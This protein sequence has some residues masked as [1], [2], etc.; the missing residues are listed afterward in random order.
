MVVVSR[1]NRKRPKYSINNSISDWQV[2]SRETTPHPVVRGD[3]RVLSHATTEVLSPETTKLLSQET[4]T[5]ERKERKENITKE[6]T[7]PRP[8]GPSGGDSNNQGNIRKGLFAEYLEAKAQ[9]RAYLS[10]VGW[11]NSL[12]APER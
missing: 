12:S 4:P 10:Y 9:S 1:D 5:K 3:N 8:Q 2:L 7:H 11:I 6:R